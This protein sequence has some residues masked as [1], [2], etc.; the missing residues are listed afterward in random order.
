MY[1][2][3]VHPE[4]RHRCSRH[5]KWMINILLN[6]WYHSYKILIILTILTKL[7]TR[8][9][10][11]SCSCLLPFIY[12][13]FFTKR[14]L[15]LRRG[16]SIR[17]AIL[18]IISRNGV[19]G[20]TAARRRQFK[21]PPFLTTF[22][23]CMFRNHAH[24]HEDFSCSTL[25]HIQDFYEYGFDGSKL[26]INKSQISGWLKSKKYSRYEPQLLMRI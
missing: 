18:V 26:A 23:D 7:L 24:S 6:I 21:L 3:F 15:V 9:G 2:S 4:M 25:I 22:Q 11:K 8:R 12:E 17:C 5:K 10:T 13:T 19:P 1:N 20:I 16:F 14:S